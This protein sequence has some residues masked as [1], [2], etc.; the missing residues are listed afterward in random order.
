MELDFYVFIVSAF[1]CLCMLVSCLSVQLSQ[2]ASEIV[3][4]LRQLTNHLL[5]TRSPRCR[6]HKLIKPIGYEYSTRML[7]LELSR[8]LAYRRLAVLKGRPGPLRAR[9]R[10]KQN[11]LVIRFVSYMHQY[12]E[13]T[14]KSYLKHMFQSE[15]YLKQGPGPGTSPVGAPFEC[16]QMLKILFSNRFHIIAY[17]Q[18]VA[19]VVIGVMFWTLNL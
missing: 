1:S 10:A 16:L 11:N 12:M 18:Q 9:A 5:T 3:G 13:L 14:W 17:I 15:S 8:S 7:P 6:M 2:L 19:R 4:Q